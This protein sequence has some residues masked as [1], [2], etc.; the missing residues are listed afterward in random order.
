[1]NYTVSNLEAIF[2]GLVLFNGGLN[3]MKTASKFLIAA[4]ALLIGVIFHKEIQEGFSEGWTS[5]M[6]VSKKENK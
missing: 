6:R 2:Y 3:R 1:M 5:A 4:I